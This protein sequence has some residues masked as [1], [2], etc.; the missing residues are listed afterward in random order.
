[1]ISHRAYTLPQIFENYVSLAIFYRNIFVCLMWKKTACQKVCNFRFESLRSVWRKMKIFWN[2]GESFTW[3]DTFNHLIFYYLIIID[4]NVF[5]NYLLYDKLAQFTIS[6][7]FGSR[8]LRPSI[9]RPKTIRPI[10]WKFVVCLIIGRNVRTKLNSNSGG[11]LEIFLFMNDM[12]LN[13]NERPISM[14]CR[15]PS[16]LYE[17]LT[18]CYRILFS[19]FCHH[20]F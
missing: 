12:I 3:V 19:R 16:A 7:N 18:D 5:K 13:R 15:F 10:V 9:L 11:S 4:N 17:K 8:T 2:N 6:L 14:R 1:M 20:E